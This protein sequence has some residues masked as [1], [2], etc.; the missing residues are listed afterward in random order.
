MYELYLQ[1][2]LGGIVNARS[3]LNEYFKQPNNDLGNTGKHIAA[4]NIQQA[5]EYIL[6]F[7]IYNNTN[8]NH[9]STNIKQVFTHDLVL[10][11]NR[12]C[13]PC[14]IKVPKN[15]MKNAHTYTTREAKRTSAR[16]LDKVV[17][18]D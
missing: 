9:N 13:I 15:I 14:G 5:I 3:A 7:C 2:A 8:Y 1:K 17:G 6:K 11:I 18:G 4:Y 12:Y 16:L 10:L